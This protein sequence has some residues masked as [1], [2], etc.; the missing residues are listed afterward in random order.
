PDDAAEAVRSVVDAVR[1][2]SLP[3]GAR[4]V[5]WVRLDGL[6]LTLRFLGPTPDDRIDATSDAVRAVAEV[7]PG[8]IELQLGG[9]GTFP[10]HGRPRALWLGIVDGAEA[11]GEV[12]TQLDAALGSAGWPSEQRPFRPHLTLARSDGVAVGPLV[13]ERLANAMA[14]RR[15]PVL[16][17]R[18]GLFESVT[19]G[20]PA[21][22]V[23]V[24][25]FPLGAMP[26]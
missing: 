6:H 1:A 18:L 13:A 17:D 11:V 25:V 12:A 10:P 21:R 26:R 14:E 16:L 2:E 8:P 9:A 23:P 5:R 20:G 7:T 3:E 15:I 22:Y 4:D 19:G 24:A